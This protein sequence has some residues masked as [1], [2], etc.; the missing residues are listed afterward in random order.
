MTYQASNQ[1][2]QLKQW[3]RWT[4]L[5]LLSTISY[6]THF[7][8]AAHSLAFGRTFECDFNPGSTNNLPLFQLK[9]ENAEESQTAGAV[10]LPEFL[11][12]IE[13]LALRSREPADGMIFDL[14][15]DEGTPLPLESGSMRFWFKPDWSSGEGPGG[16]GTL[17]S[18]GKWKAP[19]GM[20][21][22]W[23]LS[24]DPKGERI[25]FGAQSKDKGMTFIATS[26]SFMKDNWYEIVLTYDANATWVYID[27]KAHGP[28]Q[29]VSFIPP[30]SALESTGFALGNTPEGHQPVKGLIDG[31]EIFNYPL[32]QVEH[33]F[34]H[35][36][37]SAQVSKD[38][39][40]IRLQWP[41]VKDRTYEV[42][43]RLSTRE[44][45]E[46]LLDDVQGIELVD[47][48][49]D[50]MDGRVYE[51]SIAPKQTQGGIRQIEVAAYTPPNHNKGK[52]LL[53][54]DQTHW[55][56]LETDL[57][58]FVEDLQMDGWQVV[59]V[60]APRHL[61]SR[62]SPNV[63]RI[64][65]VKALIQEHLGAPVKGVK[66]A[67]LIG[68]VAVPY[69][70]YVAIDG[71][72]LRGDDHRGAW[73]CDAYYG[74]I[75][76]IWHDNAV[77]HINRTHAPA[78]N[79]PGDGKFDENQLPTR[80]EIAIGRIDFANLPSLNNGVLRNRSVKK[81][82]MEVELI[83]QYLNKNHAFRFGSLHF[84]PETLIKSHLPDNMSRPFNQS[85][86]ENASR[87][88][89]LV[90][91]EIRTGDGFQDAG[92]SLWAFMAGRSGSAS[93]ASGIRRTRDFNQPNKTPRSAFMMLY[94]SWHGDWNVSDAFLRACLASLDTGLAA[95]SG[96]VGPWHLQS[97]GRGECLG[98]A[99]LQSAN[100]SPHSATRAL[101]ILGDPTLGNYFTSPVSGLKVSMTESERRLNWSLPELKEIEG[102]YVYRLDQD[103][104][105]YMLL[106]RLSTGMTQWTLPEDM[107][108]RQRFMV[109]VAR[110]IHSSSGVFA[111]LSPGVTVVVD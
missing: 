76:G 70:G 97:L 3:Q 56:A 21:G 10:L 18:F 88:F 41:T 68:H 31:F 15:S 58:Y 49:P 104:D 39:L 37:V 50:L 89:A 42:N 27:G 66:M 36:A 63:K 77:D 105:R 14:F 106:D 73:S 108:R 29:G 35:F 99:Y 12:G 40:S 13:G 87:W 45:W 62:W 80:L 1:I 54:V 48:S 111:H 81:S 32:S 51:Y 19:P 52:V 67:I 102:V 53:L 61:D 98:F 91:G 11:P 4:Y 84:E 78:S 59:M 20:S 24:L 34:K 86:I 16:Y 43:R 7:L 6:G 93:F 23:G 109:R 96:L 47:S 79:I 17:M 90:P 28:G 103:Q 5:L 64:A 94:S 101:A 110:W 30:E 74:D 69:S 25:A 9:T 38:P 44:L 83:R 2:K 46:P 92:R 107:P 55:S 95:M 85:A 8:E 75:D 22:Y 72:T 82:K 100:Q 60:K 33:Q 57:N 71:H 26:V 65:K